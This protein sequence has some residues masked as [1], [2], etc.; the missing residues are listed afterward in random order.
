MQKV[1]SLSLLLSAI[2]VGCSSSDTQKIKDSVNETIDKY[3]GNQPMVVDDN[4]VGVDV[5]G[6]KKELLDIHNS[7]RRALGLED[8]FYS[9]TL[10]KRAQEYADKLASSGK[11][12]HDPTNQT[13][14]L[15]TSIGENL[16]ASTNPNVTF[17]RAALVWAN[18]KRYYHYGKV[19]DSGTCDNTKKCGHY[20]QMI[21]KNSTKVGCAKARYKQGS[22]SG[23][24]VIVCKYYPVG[25]IVGSYPY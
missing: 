18:E 7:E 20:T 15:K 17:K 3:K 14:D 22:Y 12:E 19:G 9:D 24:Y 11:F 1:I 10:E 6:D 8:I 2:F 5:E 21:W 16:Y 4:E 23:G 13:K 25:N